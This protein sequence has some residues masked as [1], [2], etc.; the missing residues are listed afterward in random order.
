MQPAPTRSPA[1]DWAGSLALAAPAAVPYLSHLA[2]AGWA[3]LLPTGFIVHDM[4][5][6]MANAREHFDGGG[7]R[8]LYGLPFSPSDATPALYFQVHTLLL[9][10]AW[11][12]TGWDVGLVFVLFGVAAAWLCARLALALYRDVVGLD[13]LAH[14]LGLVVFFWGGGVLAAAGALVWLLGGGSPE[15][16][17]TFEPL[18]ALDPFAGWWFLNFGRNLI[19]PPEAFYHALFFGAVLSLRRGRYGLAAALA[20]CLVLSHPF[21]G[22]ELTLILLAW[23]VLERGLSGNRQVPG[24]FLATCLG[25]VAW[26]GLYYGLV[27]GRSAEH[28][29]VVEQ[30][31]LPWL[32]E[33]QSIL[34]AYLLVG[35]LAAWRVRTAARARSFLALPENRLLLVW[36]A[37]ALALAK[38]ELVVPRPMMP[39][40]F[41][42]GYIW[43]ALFLMGAPVLVDLFQRLLTLRHRVV[44]AV[45][46]ASVMVVLLADN[47]LWLGTFPWRASGWQ[48][49]V[50]L[51][52]AEEELFTYLGGAAPRGVLVVPQTRK[53]GY[54]TTVYTPLRSW[55]SHYGA[56]PYAR[57]RLQEL[58]RFF[59]EGVVPEAW[60][61]R[62]L[63]VVFLRDEVP[64]SPP[65]W[66]RGAE[67][68]FANGLFAVYRV[69]PA[70]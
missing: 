3:G 38:H 28:R 4:A 41:T 60:G 53:V 2:R 18:F 6:H 14:R 32:L 52:P 23:S 25:L 45:A 42:R 31:M 40:H 10:L 35:L 69:E 5:L 48:E 54:L 56:T 68:V 9:G 44:G 57:A 47:G 39:V 67:R 13:G 64:L 66:M 65:A 21:T 26:Q 22:L 61:S 29:S 37:V 58:T 70:R 12:L 33:S 7:F 11:R 8:L 34:P 27:L 17:S 20:V 51:A 62:P 16:L 63:L 46:V 30:F 50:Y 1:R 49:S 24:P 36:F 15:G 43:T 19:L 55:Y 59:G